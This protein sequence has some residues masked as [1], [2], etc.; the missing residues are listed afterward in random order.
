MPEDLDNLLSTVAASAAGAARPDGPEAARRRG[1]QRT[2]RRRL[3]LSALSAALV[4]G[5]VGAALAVGHHGHGAAPLPPAIGPSGS[6]GPSTPG[7]S[8]SP[9]SGSTSRAGSTAPTLTLQLPAALAEGAPNQ[10]G[11]TVVNPGP[12]RTET[13]TLDLGAPTTGAPSST[14]PDERGVVQRRDPADGAWVPVPVSYSRA[15][16]GPSADIA[17]YRLAL[18]SQGTVVQAL[19]V[20]PVGVGT[21][22]FQ[23]GLGD[24]GSTVAAQ[25]RTLP[26]VTP[27]LTGAGPA[28]VAPGTTSAEFDFTLT[29]R[30]AAGYSAV[31]LYLDAYGSTPDCSFSPFPTVQWWDG[32]SWRTVSLAAPWP[33]LDTVP[34]PAGRSV[35]LRTRLIVPASLASCLKQGQVALTAATGPDAPNGGGSSSDTTPPGFTARG[36]S[37]FFAIR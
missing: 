4:V 31:G 34:V 6:A 32:G 1:A 26:L 16:S 35:T 5:G 12:A 19:R 30:T 17:T 18:P 14:V 9:T 27:T 20:T 23:V 7:P 10:V 22:D 37:P 25:S 21:V 13:V 15:A 24:G 2:V 29:N 11:F 3:A 8:A 28:S 36:D 33:L